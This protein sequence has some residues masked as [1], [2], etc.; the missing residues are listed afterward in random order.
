MRGKVVIAALYVATLVSGVSLS[1]MGGVRQQPAPWQ[2]V[3]LIVG[4]AIA[5]TAA[6]F[7]LALM[8][9]RLLF[10]I[11]WWMAQ[12]LGKDVYQYDG[13][14]FTGLRLTRVP[15]R[16]Q[17]IV[18]GVDDEMRRWD[19]LF[20]VLMLALLPLHAVG[21]M[22]VYRY[23][24]RHTPRWIEFPQTLHYEL[25]SNL[26][27]LREWNQ[28]WSP[29][30]VLRARISRTL[31]QPNPSGEQ[32]EE[33]WFRLAQ[34]HLLNSYRLRRSA[35]EP[36]RYTP[37]DRVFF[38][39]VQAA[40]AMIYLNRIAA[41][42]RA[43]ATP[44]GSGA[45]VLTGL[46]HL[47]DGNYAR[48]DEV[49]EQALVAMGPAPG[50]ISRPQA[51]LLAAQAAM[52]NHRPE[53]A[54][55]LL[56]GLLADAQAPVRIQALA[57]EHYAEL[58]RLAGRREIAP[59]LL[60]RAEKSYTTLEDRS[61]LARVHLRRAAL[62][63]AEGRE[64]EARGEVSLASSLSAGMEDWFTLNMVEWLTLFFPAS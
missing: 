44:W 52:L 37:G 43:N 3:L 15:N 42:P 11:Y 50:A 31:L 34:L 38:D 6:S 28:P 5:L 63:L 4:A 30:A 62:A 24:E 56:E 21:A 32:S 26:P 13:V 12:V 14:Y 8:V 35:N 48:A 39:R 36:Y 58:M 40:R 20:G 23:A 27:L 25:L 41:S 1:V 57:L 45:M 10:P 9:A 16:L 7:L 55:K 2:D 53:R 18:Y 59:E 46:Y 64:A 17:R 47:S 19:W 33:Q 22:A 54:A 60:R 51:V 29:Q 49:L 61:G